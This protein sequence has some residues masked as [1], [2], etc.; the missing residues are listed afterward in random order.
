MLVYKRYE[1]FEDFILS[2][3]TFY[4]MLTEIAVAFIINVE[5]ERLEMVSGYLVPETVFTVVI[6]RCCGSYQ[7]VDGSGIFL[8]ENVARL[9]FDEPEKYRLKP[10]AGFHEHLFWK[11]E[12]RSGE[13]AATTIDAD[14]GTGKKYYLC[15]FYNFIILQIDCGVRP[16]LTAKVNGTSFQLP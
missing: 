13:V 12:K 1:T 5:H 7:S 8:G 2:G 16:S 15:V 9:F 6:Y 4:F 11:F 10:H 14:N 3:T